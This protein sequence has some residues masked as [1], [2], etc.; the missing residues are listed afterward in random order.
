MP[1]PTLSPGPVPLALPLVHPLDDFYA[2]A[3]LPLPCIEAMAGED[4]PEP[5]KALL[6]HANDMTPTLETFYGQRIHLRLLRRQ[7]RDDV[8][9]REV[10][11]MLEDDRTRIEFGATKINLVLLPPAARRLILEEH[12]PLGSILASCGVTHAS[13]PKAFLNLRSDAFINSALGLTG[14][15]LLFGRR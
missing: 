8:Y 3:K 15:Q 9:F 13:R 6:V 7:H 4:V 12:V 2:Q 10:V 11:L 1:D 14:S 5:Y